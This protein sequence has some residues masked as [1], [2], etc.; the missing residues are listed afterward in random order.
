MGFSVSHELMIREPEAF[1]S[2]G[3][4]GAL[5]T[6]FRAELLREF[7]KRYSNGGWRGLDVTCDQL[8]RL[9]S[10]ELSDVVREIWMRDRPMPISGEVP[11]A[12][13]N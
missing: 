10:A 8:R 13:L 5:P 9:A 11:C 12:W 2:A 6:A 4:A 3:D 1:L 7:C